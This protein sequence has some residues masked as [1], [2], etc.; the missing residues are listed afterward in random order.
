MLMTTRIPAMSANMGKSYEAPTT[1]RGIR[2]VKD[3]FMNDSGLVS[4]D[5]NRQQNLLPGLSRLGKTVSTAH[6]NVSGECE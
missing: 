5:E 4:T 6:P 2:P 3:N 1:G